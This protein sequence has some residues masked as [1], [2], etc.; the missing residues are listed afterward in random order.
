MVL[1]GTCAP[2]VEMRIVVDGTVI[3]EDEI[4]EVQVNCPQRNF[5]SYWGEPD[6]TC[7]SFT[8]DGWWRTGDLGRLRGGMLSVHGRAKDVLVV[9]GK[10]FSLAEIDAEIETVVSAGD[11]A[12]S[13]AVH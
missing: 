12:F 4:G 9:S 10:K 2:G 6:A 5:S 7:Q 11:R 3:S 8:D 1:L 13:C